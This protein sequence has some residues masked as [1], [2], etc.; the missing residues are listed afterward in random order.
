MLLWQVKQLANVFRLHLKWAGSMSCG[1][2]NASPGA[3]CRHREVD[4]PPQPHEVPGK[5]V[6]QGPA[7]NKDGCRELSWLEAVFQSM[8]PL[9][10]KWDSFQY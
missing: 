6:Y 9:V 5:W 1:V 4:P 3:A 8:N 10:G 7:N 2:R